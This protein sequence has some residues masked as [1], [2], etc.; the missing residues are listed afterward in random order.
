MDLSVP[1]EKCLRHMSIA[2][3]VCKSLDPSQSLQ[4]CWFH[5]VIHNSAANIAICV[6]DLKYVRYFIGGVAWT[7]ATTNNCFDSRLIYL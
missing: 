4:K 2:S 7:K 6:S 5:I 1:Q 3:P